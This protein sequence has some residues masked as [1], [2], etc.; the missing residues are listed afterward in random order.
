MGWSDGG[1]TF[2]R[3]LAAAAAALSGPSGGKGGGKGGG[4]SRRVQGDGGTK[5][6]GNPWQCRWADCRAARLRQTTFG[7]RTECFVCMRPKAQALSPPAHSVV[8]W[9]ASTAGGRESAGKGAAAGDSA[10]P[11][12]RPPGSP[13]SKQAE[14]R[15][16][17]K[18]RTGADELAPPAPATPAATSPGGAAASAAAATA[19]VPAAAGSGAPTG[20]LA[21]RSVALPD[22]VLA[23]VELLLPA[24]GPVRDSL[25]RDFLPTTSP[26][27]RAAE[28]TLKK[29]LAD[30]KPCAT[31]AER[32]D[33]ESEVARLQAVVH[34]FGDKD[35]SEAA[36]DVRRRLSAAQAA[37]GK[38]H[39][40]APS[41]EMERHG[42]LEAKAAFERAVQ[43]RRDRAAAGAAKTAERK[44]ERARFF[45][46]LREQV[47][48]AAAAVRRAEE[49]HAEPMG[50]H[51]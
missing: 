51:G 20:S 45:S 14:K 5:G 17:R 42:L 36:E 10:A 18:Q 28:D 19:P 16:R 27:A 46:A 3:V 43:G 24:L 32:A 29:F 9:A 50:A 40:K 39:S 1:P 8:H 7:D 4:S 15:R 2:A 35:K 6:T 41:A 44:E 47:D 23:E 37:L 22:E 33:M 12:K 11:S 34:A 31:V 48:R 26:P 38:L 25:A 13:P 21:E 30:S 49:E